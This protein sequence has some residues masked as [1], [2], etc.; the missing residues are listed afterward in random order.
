LPV[1]IVAKQEETAFFESIAL[2]LQGCQTVELA[3][4]LYISES[5]QLVKKLIGHR[6]PFEMSGDDHLKDSLGK[7]VRTFKKLNRNSDLIERL[8]R[9]SVERNFLSHEAIVRAMNP[10]GELDA[11]DDVLAR[12]SRI[13]AE[14]DRLA[15][16]LHEESGSIRAQLWFNDLG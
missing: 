4:K 5:L 11:T 12:A 13:Q 7:L 15:T 14:A 1:S 6:M 3:L 8:E 16:Q 9:F 2:A 10:D